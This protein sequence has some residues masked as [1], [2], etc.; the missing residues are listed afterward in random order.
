[1]DEYRFVSIVWVDEAI[2]LLAAKPTL[3]DS[4]FLA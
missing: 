4:H 1:V 2:A 3:D